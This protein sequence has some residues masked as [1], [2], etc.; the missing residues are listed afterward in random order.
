MVF[1]RRNDGGA[2]MVVRVYV[3]VF[4]VGLPRADQRSKYPTVHSHPIIIIFSSRLGSWSSI[5]LDRSLALT[6]IRRDREAIIAALMESIESSNTTQ[7][8][9]H[10]LRGI[11]NLPS[12]SRLWFNQTESQQPNHHPLSHVDVN[13]ENP[14]SCQIILAASAM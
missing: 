8:S 2:A 10:H 1:G 9:P 14:I 7:Y 13:T 6:I 12:L 11:H 3:C 4:Q 5:D